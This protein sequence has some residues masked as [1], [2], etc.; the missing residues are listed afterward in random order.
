MN[1]SIVIRTF[2]EAN[3]IG[4]TLASIRSQEFNGSVEIVVVDSEST[5][6]T[7]A[8]AREFDDDLDLIVEEISQAEFSYGYALNVGAQAANG[9]FVVNLS[10]HCPS[11]DDSWLR[12]LIRPL[13]EDNTVAATYGKQISD[14]SI[15]PFEAIER[16]DVFGDDQRIHTEPG[17]NHAFSNANCAIRRSVWASHK[18]DEELTYAEDRAWA[19]DVLG[20]GH[21]IVYVP[22]AAV[23]HTHEFALRDVY[24][25]ARNST[26]AGLRLRNDRNDA[27][28]MLRDLLDVPLYGASMTYQLTIQ[29]N[30]HYVPWALP[31]AAARRAGQIVAKLEARNE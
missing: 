27:A 6:G 23:S 25:R 19:T 15:N 14:P 5:D 26:L 8:A 1:V 20:A 31:F 12:S 3:A 29:G 7:V 9:E 2:N 24:D 18:F 17:D 10:A 16:K 28:A 13:E 21:D 11:T 4:E 22:E 30:Y